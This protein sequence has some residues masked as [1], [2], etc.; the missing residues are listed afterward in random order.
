MEE[1]AVALSL[2]PETINKFFAQQVAQ[3]VLGE[4]LH[5]VLTEEVRRLSSTFESPLKPIVG[6]YIRQVAREVLQQ[7]EFRK[8]VEEAIREQLTPERVTAMVDK[9]M[10]RVST[11]IGYDR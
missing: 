8:I 10:E 4:T 11:Q 2:D 5:K 6:E 1:P 3:S 7:P 9:V